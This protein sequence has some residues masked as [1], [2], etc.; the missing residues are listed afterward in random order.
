MNVNDSF[1]FIKL[2]KNLL[3][4]KEIVKYPA[5]EDLSHC[6]KIA[7]VDCKTVQ[8]RLRKNVIKIKAYGWGPPGQV[9]KELGKKFEMFGL[10]KKK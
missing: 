2:M 7:I 6:K 3:L 9:L 1:I 10:T 5:V 8:S 4:N